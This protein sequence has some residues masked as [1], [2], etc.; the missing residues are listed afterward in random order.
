MVAVNVAGPPS[1]LTLKKITGPPP[2]DAQVGEANTEKI[3]AD[4]DPLPSNNARVV[5]VTIEPPPMD[6][7]NDRCLMLPSGMA[8]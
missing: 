7:Q 8:G 4:A 6:R 1:W 3:C 5:Q 2:V